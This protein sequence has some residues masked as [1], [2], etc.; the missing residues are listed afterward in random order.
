MWNSPL[1]SS[2]VM[3]RC[4]GLSFASRHGSS[5]FS[6]IGANSFVFVINTLFQSINPIRPYS[7]G[8]K[9][10][11]IHE[12]YKIIL[13]VSVYP[14]LCKCLPSPNSPSTSTRWLSICFSPS[15]NFSRAYGFA[16]SDGIDLRTGSLFQVIIP[17]IPPCCSAARKSK[18]RQIY[19]VGHKYY[20]V[21]SHTPFKW[22]YRW[23]TRFITPKKEIICYNTT[24]TYSW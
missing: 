2:V 6:F 19:K 13:K 16:T 12:N 18:S 20:R 3:F 23:V 22:P 1:I 8:K 9:V 4:F 5:A 14:F 10:D 24:P 17:D 7:D 15:M 11:N 21:V